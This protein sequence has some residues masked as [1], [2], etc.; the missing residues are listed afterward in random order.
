MNLR[1]LENGLHHIWTCRMS[2]AS[3]RLTQYQDDGLH[4]VDHCLLVFDLRGVLAHAVV[5]AAHV[6]EDA[7]VDGHHNHEDQQVQHGPEHQVTAA[8]ERS[9][10]GA[11][12]NVA[13]AVPSHSGNQSHHYGDDPDA[14]DEHHDSVVGHFTVQ[15]HGEDGL[16]S[17]QCDG[18]QINHRGRQ[19]G[20]DQT[21]SHAKKNTNM[22]RE[23]RDKY[24][25]IPPL[26]Y[27]R[28]S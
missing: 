9:H 22:R 24:L 23:R 16:V 3:M 14:D 2:E 1:T 5:L 15:L 12:A 26:N 6:D 13:H 25:N 8:V 20:V 11:H 19:T 7:R 27:W 18:H 10:V 17:L 28:T 21:L 4:E